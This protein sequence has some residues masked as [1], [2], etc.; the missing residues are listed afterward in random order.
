MSF[1]NSRLSI[2]SL[3]GLACILL[4]AFHVIGSDLSNGLKISEGFL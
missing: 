2:D 4:V 1:K 3:R